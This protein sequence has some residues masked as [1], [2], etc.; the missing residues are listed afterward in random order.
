M[1]WLTYTIAGIFKLYEQLLPTWV[2]LGICEPE[3]PYRFRGRGDVQIVRQGRRERA[4]ILS[5]HKTS[6]S[7]DTTQR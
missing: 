3:D 5:G 6:T 7:P 1:F 2:Y 4:H